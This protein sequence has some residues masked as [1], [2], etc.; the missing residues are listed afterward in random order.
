MTVGP[1]MLKMSYGFEGSRTI[2]SC[3]T[4]C[5]CYRN[6]CTE[7]CR[8]RRRDLETEGKQLRRELK[9]KDDRYLAAEREMQVN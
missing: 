6:E 4:N 9:L 5:Y 2:L 8:A 1:I 7:S 3:S